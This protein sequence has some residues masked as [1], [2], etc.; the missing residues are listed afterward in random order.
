MKKVYYKPEI[1]LVT[2]NLKQALLNTSPGP[3]SDYMD[4]PT[5]SGGAPVR[6]NNGVWDN[7][8]NY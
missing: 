3:N 5:I 7:D 2:V 8:R 4:N 1:L 6:E